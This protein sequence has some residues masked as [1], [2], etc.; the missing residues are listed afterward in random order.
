MVRSNTRRM[1][2]WVE[3]HP[4]LWRV[5][6][7]ST[8]RRERRDMGLFV[9]RRLRTSPRCSHRLCRWC[10]QRN[11]TKLSYK[12]RDGP[13][14]LYFCYDDHALEWL[15]YRHKNPSI[16]AMLRRPPA[17]RDLG[18]KTIDEWIRD[19]LSHQGTDAAPTPSH[20]ADGLCDVAHVEVSV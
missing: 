16:N 18:G 19:E 6:K 9:P 3:E 1:I 20:A 11:L 8:S 10:G 2:S 14:Y 13:F 7:A 17:Q 4:N 5:H 15:Y 12:L